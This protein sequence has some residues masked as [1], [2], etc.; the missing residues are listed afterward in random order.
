MA[1]CLLQELE[2]AG[3]YSLISVTEHSTDLAVQAALRYESMGADALMLLPPHF[4]NPP[5]PAIQR[6]IETVL[7]A[8]RLPVLIQ[9]A[10]IETGR[11]IPVE[12]MALI[13]NR[14]PNARFKIEPNPPMD[15]IR[16]LLALA[17][18]SCIMLGYAGLY[19]LDVLKIGGKGTIPG[20]SFA[21]IYLDIH[22]SW[23]RG[24]KDKARQIHER[25]LPYIKRWMFNT[26]Y[27]ISVE[28]R[29]AQLRG[30]IPSAYCREPGYALSEDDEQCFARFFEE[31]AD[32]F[33][34]G[35][36]HERLL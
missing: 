16:A 28:K 3:T 29:I 9:Y 17:P 27:L 4:M 36:E 1:Q 26:E 21:E 34:K 2:G 15:Y 22:N 20:C 30:L 7:R 14:Y 33:R 6:H 11:S 23:L 31:F 18:H 32:Y 8:V 19:M 25:L 5:L 12:T 35:G 13:A 10:P 24:E